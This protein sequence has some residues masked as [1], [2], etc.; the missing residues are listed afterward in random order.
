VLYC[1]IGIVAGLIAAALFTTLDPAPINY[2]FA[3]FMCPH[4]G[5]VVAVHLE[6]TEKTEQKNAATIKLINE[7]DKSAS[8]WCTDNAGILSANLAPGKYRMYMS[9]NGYESAFAMIN[10][11]DS[12]PTLIGFPNPVVLLRR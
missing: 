5:L 9:A 12:S 4:K 6:D 3:R 11:E 8:Q 1:A 2:L 7:Q 10:I